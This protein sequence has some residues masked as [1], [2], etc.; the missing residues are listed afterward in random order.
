MRSYDYGNR[1][2]AINVQGVDDSRN[3]TQDG[4]QNVD[5]EISSASALEEDTKRWEDDGKNDLANIAEGKV[6]TMHWEGKERHGACATERSALREDAYLAVKG[7]MIVY[8]YNVL[9]WK[10]YG[11]WRKEG[12]KAS[13]T[14]QYLYRQVSAK[15]SAA[16]LDPA[17]TRKPQLPTPLSSHPPHVVMT[18][19]CDDVAALSSSKRD[20]MGGVARIC[21]HNWKHHVT[22]RPANPSTLLLFPVLKIGTWWEDAVLVSS[23][24]PSRSGSRSASRVGAGKDSGCGAVIQYQRRLTPRISPK[25]SKLS[26]FSSTAT[27]TKR[28]RARGGQRQF[29]V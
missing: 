6:S 28:G 27:L 5:Q 7:M 3:V 19:T 18:H 26:Q 10:M 17:V 11:V 13:R 8:G 12:E 1:G 15:R 22:A 23:L 2:I 24:F 16:G 25:V 4:Q 29:Q 9:K 21:R 20:T 14:Q